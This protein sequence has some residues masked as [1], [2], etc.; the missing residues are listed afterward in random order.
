MNFEDEIKQINEIIN[1]LDII[2]EDEWQIKEGETEEEYNE[3]IEEIEEELEEEL[4]DYISD[5]LLDE[6]KINEEDAVKEAQEKIK[7]DYELFE[8]AFIKNEDGTITLKSDE[9]LVELGYDNPDELEKLRDIEKNMNNSDQYLNAIRESIKASKDI[10][11]EIDRKMEL[12]KS[13][14]TAKKRGESLPS[15][16]NPN[17]QKDK[18]EKANEYIA[19]TTTLKRIPVIQNEYIKNNYI[20]ERRYNNLIR[21]NNVNR[22]NASNNRVVTSTATVSSTPVINNVVSTAN[23]V[24]KKIPDRKNVVYSNF[25]KKLD[26]DNDLTKQK[27]KARTELKLIFKEIENKELLGEDVEELNS[28]IENIKKKYPNTITDKVLDRLYD[29][30]NVQI[31]V[32]ETEQQIQNAV[33]NIEQEAQAEIEEIIQ[34]IE[35]KLESI[36]TSETIEDTDNSKEK[37]QE[38]ANEVIDSINDIAKSK[39]KVEIKVESP[40]TKIKQKASDV[41]LGALEVGTVVGATLGTLKKKSGEKIDDL[42]KKGEDLVENIVEQQKDAKKKKN[43][44]AKKETAKNSKNSK[45]PV[46]ENKTEISKKEKAIKNNNI[47]SI[48]NNEENTVKNIQQSKKIS[49]SELI[50]SLDSV[51]KRFSDDEIRTKAIDLLVINK[52]V[53]YLKEYDDTEMQTRLKEEINKL[54]TKKTGLYNDDLCIYHYTC[55]N[56]KTLYYMYNSYQEGVKSIDGS[57]EI[58]P[59]NKN[60][61]SYYL[62]L[63]HRVKNDFKNSDW[64]EV[65]NKIKQAEK[66]GKEFPLSEKERVENEKRIESHWELQP[67]LDKEIDDKFNSNREE[68]CY[69]YF[70]FLKDKYNNLNELSGVER[71]KAESDFTSELDLVKSSKGNTEYLNLAINKEII[72][73]IAKD[74]E[75]FVK[76]I[77]TIENNNNNGEKINPRILKLLGDTYFKGLRSSSNQEIVK[78]DKRKAKKIYEGIITEKELSNDVELYNNLFNIYNDNSSPLYDKQKAEKLKKIANKKGVNIQ[79]GIMS[80]DKNE[81]PAIYVCSDLHGEYPTYQTIVKKLKDKDKLY[82]LGDVID[83][84]PDGIKILQDLMKKKNNN[85]EFLIGNHEYNMIKTLY[86]NDKKAEKIWESK[87]EFEKLDA[88]EQEKIK[89]FLLDSYVY[90]S[91]NVNS[92]KI[93][94]VHANANAV[95]DKEENETVRQMITK[96][97]EKIIQNAVEGEQR[98]IQKTFTI[99]GH[100]PTFNMIKYK[101]GVLDIDCGASYGHS[102]ALV[103]LTNG[104]VNYIDAEYERNKEKIKN[105]KSK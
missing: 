104:T 7:K 14:I 51:R 66:E 90:K 6:Q 86:F 98:K 16:L 83:R 8:D 94:L 42:K 26:K 59:A 21:N 70:E 18:F 46:T 96:G 2:Q 15:N 44:K 61:A 36:E 37:I 24:T 17:L 5:S 25:E 12:A 31:K 64:K 72:S 19:S 93:N 3:R 62:Y 97:K 84:G 65:E 80:K 67:Y 13:I 82:I 41:A 4:L 27:I 69:G 73:R 55:T 50:E 40:A 74:D 78:Q 48:A 28:K 29:K 32:N 88:K 91:I 34:N 89:N 87:N 20:A 45:K 23:I 75:N 9:E 47:A 22:G 77:Q 54:Q 56:P 102:A 79:Q 58:I 43:D 81:E 52:L 99:V 49:R 63:A 30:Y 53:C 100:N 101:N 95:P 103:N 60:V 39:P 38:K 11:A 33:E 85:I 35:G 76:E 92:Q 68:I 10:D 1:K 71:L 57:R 105:E